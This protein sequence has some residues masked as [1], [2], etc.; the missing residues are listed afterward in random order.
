MTDYS[1]QI[2]RKPDRRVEAKAELPKDLVPR[3]ENLADED[4]VPVS[5][6]VMRHLFFFERYKGV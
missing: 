3:L 5:R 1:L 6:I 2:S 4:W